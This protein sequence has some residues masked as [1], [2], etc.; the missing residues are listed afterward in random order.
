MVLMG[1]ESDGQLHFH[2]SG[3]PNLCTTLV[4]HPD[5]EPPTPS[6]KFVGPQYVLTKRFTEEEQE[7]LR[8]FR[9]RKYLLPSSMC[10]EHDF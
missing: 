2:V 7:A 10:D 1:E 6:I 4:E 5:G 9:V 8:S 3:L